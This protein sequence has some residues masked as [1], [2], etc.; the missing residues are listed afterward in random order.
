MRP[1]GLRWTPAGQRRCHSPEGGHRPPVVG[2][3]EERAQ[4][5]VE[6]CAVPNMCALSTCTQLGL[7]CPGTP[8]WWCLD[9]RLCPGSM[10]WQSPAQVCSEAYSQLRHRRCHPQVTGHASQL[11]S[12]GAR[13]SVTSQEGCAL[14][15]AWL[16]PHRMGPAL[17]QAQDGGEQGTGR[18]SSVAVLAVQGC[19]RRQNCSATGVLASPLPLQVKD[20]RRV[21]GIQ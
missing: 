12:R 8:T 14:V 6:A 11:L 20:G 10:V 21:T 18:R 16:C 1:G 4:R 13:V 17:C 5:D 7:Y 9:P 19:P 15:R 2:A 3:E